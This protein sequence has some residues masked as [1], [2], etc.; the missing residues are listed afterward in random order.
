MEQNKSQEPEPEPES[1]PA[2][3][4]VNLTDACTDI[5][6]SDLVGW[7]FTTSKNI[8]ITDLGFMTDITGILKNSHKIRIHENGNETSLIEETISNDDR[9][10]N[11][12]KYK[13]L[14]SPV[15]LTQGTNYIILAQRDNNNEDLVYTMLNEKIKEINFN[16]A[17]NFVGNIAEN[18][19]TFKY[20]ENNSYSASHGIA[21][22]CD[23]FKFI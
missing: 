3:T 12:T 10:E 7:E 13:K 11:Q 6:T 2:L 16:E 4:I 5:S 19:E 15:V 20:T 23:I 8:T 21:F 18:S 14:D 9:F 1:E 22:I 17:I